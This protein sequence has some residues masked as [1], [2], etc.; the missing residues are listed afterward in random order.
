VARGH[1]LRAALL[2]CALAAGPESARAGEADVVS[3]SAE[4]AARVCRFVVSVRHADEGWQH[5]ADRYEVLAP[6]GSV[7]A[8]RVLRHPHVTE[9]PVTRELEGVVIPAGLTRVR[10]RAHDGVHEYGGAEA[11]VEIRD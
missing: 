3:A 11:S 5:Y 10:V 9:Q 8:T 1:L 6:D 7:L 2:A 4:C